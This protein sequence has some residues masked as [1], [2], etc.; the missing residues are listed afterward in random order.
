MHS[1]QND[2][3]KL[4]SILPTKAPNL[5]VLKIRD[6]HPDDYINDSINLKKL[7]FLRLEY[8]GFIISNQVSLSLFFVWLCYL[9][10]LCIL[11]S[12]V[13]LLYFQQRQ[14]LFASIPSLIYLYRAKFYHRSSGRVWHVPIKY[15]S[16]EEP[17][18]HES[19]I[20]AKVVLRHNNIWNV[21]CAITHGR[22]PNFNFR[23]C[24]KKLY[25]IA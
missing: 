13:D 19:K 11:Y 9:L 7:K 21:S 15:R 12:I 1:F 20:L 14:Q 8:S 18:D 5:E 17:C 4:L 10:C 3:A 16:L 23:A 24:V 6:L 25:S 2:G 22:W